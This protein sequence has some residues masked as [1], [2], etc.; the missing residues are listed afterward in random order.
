MLRNSI[1]QFRMRSSY[2]VNTC[3]FIVSFRFVVWHTCQTTKVF[4]HVFNI[5]GH[6]CVLAYVQHIRS[7]LCF[8][9]C[10]TYRVTVVFWHVFNISGHCCVLACV[11]HIGSLLCF[12]TFQENLFSFPTKSISVT[13][14]L[15]FYK[16][17]SVW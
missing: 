12:I 11:H 3:V 10:S 6:C 8:G 9:M 14:Q 2:W 4:W 17:M 1:I 13:I 7:L 15:N 16:F 5:S